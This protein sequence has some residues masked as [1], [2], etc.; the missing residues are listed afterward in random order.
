MLF[1]LKSK[2][3]IH[4][5]TDL[6]Q[7]DRLLRAIEIASFYKESPNA[8]AA[9][10]KERPHMQPKVYGI[11]FERSALR[12][13]IYTRLVNRIEAGMIEE[14]EAIHQNGYSWEKLES[15][16]LEYRF[17]AEYLQNKIPSK[18]AYIDTLFRAICQFAKRQETWF[19]RMEKNGV[20]I[21]WLEGI[22]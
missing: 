4:N 6:E 19:R 12:K 17:T 13:R 9:A 16:G 14:V 22:S 20:H 11:R 5:K 21:H 10:E 1:S 3:A 8:R 15:L 2:E 18:E 7:R